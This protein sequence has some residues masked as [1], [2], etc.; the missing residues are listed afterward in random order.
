VKLLP[1][2]I[3]V[4]VTGGGVA[5]QNLVITRLMD[6]AANADA[7]SLV[8]ADASAGLRRIRA[9]AGPMS[10]AHGAAAREDITR[11]LQRPDAA[12]K[13]TDPLPTPPGEPI[14]GRGGK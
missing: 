3:I 4:A 6:L 14:G 11:F 8:R 2:E 5:V 10:S 13:R 7:S 9:I 12:H 1:G